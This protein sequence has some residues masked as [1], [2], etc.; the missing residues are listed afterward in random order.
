MTKYCGGAGVAF[1]LGFYCNPTA[2][3][4]EVGCLNQPASGP[5]WRTTA[6]EL[7]ASLGVRLDG[8]LVVVTGANVGL[9]REAAKTFYE[10][11]ATVVMACRSPQ[12]AE[13]GALLHCCG[14]NAGGCQKRWELQKTKC[15]QNLGAVKNLGVPK[16][17]LAQSLFLFLRVFTLDM[18]YAYP[19]CPGVFVQGVCR[20]CVVTGV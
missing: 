3:L 18:K 7:A 17:Q 15:T 9:G 19:R 4:G 12:R 10:L 6:Q 1:T 2:T 11:G 5:G 16:L 8:K 13:A 14:P 20:G